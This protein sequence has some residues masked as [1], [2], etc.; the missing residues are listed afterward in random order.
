MDIFPITSC[1][2]VLTPQK[3][4]QD[5]FNQPNAYLELNPSMHITPDGSITILVRRVNY[6]KFKDRQFTLYE[7]KS[8]SSYVVLRGTIPANNSPLSTIS[9]TAEDLSWSWSAEYPSYPTYWLGMEDIR[10]C[11]ASTILLTVPEKNPS[12]NP[13]IF[14]GTLEGSQIHTISRCDPSHTEKNWMPFTT[15]E[16]IC[17]VIYNVQPFQVKDILTDSKETIPF[18]TPDLQGYHGSTNGIIFGHSWRLFLIHTN[19]ERSY[20]RWLLYNPET[21]EIRYSKPFVFFQY[22]YIE[23]PCS[24][25][26]Y[27]GTIYISLGV[28]DDKAYI[29]TVE[30]AEIIAWIP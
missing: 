16:G 1:C 8:V 23:F 13:C 27:N 14:R 11:D 20:H 5:R 25:C 6:R 2:P 19:K 3:Q 21:N 4:F 24:L 18:H 15:V 26:E 9:M 10:F 30:K 7:P 22:S 29:L 28:N 17:K 12:G